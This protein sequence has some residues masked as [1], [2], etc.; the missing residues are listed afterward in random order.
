[1][2]SKTPPP[3]GHDDNPEWTDE[4][5]ATARPASE[6]LPKEA[7]AALVRKVGRPRGSTSSIKE[8]VSLRIDRDIL[9]RFRASG[10]GWQTRINEA[11][12]KAVQP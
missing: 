6:V 7:V 2:V 10:P 5:F 1:M 3:T 11:L 12:R 8:A 4:D 9:D